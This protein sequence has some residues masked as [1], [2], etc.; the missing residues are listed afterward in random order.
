M[1]SNVENFSLP[2]KPILTKSNPV[3]RIITSSLCSIPDLPRIPRGVICA[4]G[5]VTRSTLLRWRDLRYLRDRYS[6]ISFL[7]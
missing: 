5:S 4:I 1:K 7:P 2:K 6:R 3:A